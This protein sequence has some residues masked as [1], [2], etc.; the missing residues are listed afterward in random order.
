LVCTAAALILVNSGFSQQYLDFSHTQFGLILS[1]F[2]FSMSLSHWINEGLMALFFFL[3]G[4][5]I[6][7]EVLVG[8]IREVDKLV[9]IGFAALGGMAAPAAVYYLFNRGPPY[10]SGWG[11]HHGDRHCVR[12]WHTGTAWQENPSFYIY[13]FNSPSHPR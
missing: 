9:P 13:V 10:D 7:R 5:E 3:L 8:D 11:D 12:R 1:D 6:K 4:M 2:S